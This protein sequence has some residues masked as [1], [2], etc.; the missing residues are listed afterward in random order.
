[1]TTVALLVAGGTSAGGLTALVAKKLRAN[2]DARNSSEKPNP[3]RT[4]HEPQ[5]VGISE[6]R[7][8]D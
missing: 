6:S 1:M 4:H 5:Q 2:R 8:P 3:R 7:I